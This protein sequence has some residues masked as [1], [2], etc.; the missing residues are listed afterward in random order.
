MARIIHTESKRERIDAD[1]EAELEKLKVESIVYSDGRKAY[2]KL[3]LNGFHHKR[4]NHE[5]ALAN[6]KVPIN[7]PESSLGYAKS[8]SPWL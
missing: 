2:N 3:S 1:R 8:L 7:G 6:G 4:I 5:K